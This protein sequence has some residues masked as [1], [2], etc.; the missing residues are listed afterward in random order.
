ME[1]L[2]NHNA[3][4]KPESRVTGGRGFGLEHFDLVLALP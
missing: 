1:F 4:V 2:V 3:G